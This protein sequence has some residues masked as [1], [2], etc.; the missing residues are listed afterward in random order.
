VEFDEAVEAISARLAAQR[1]MSRQHSH[2]L[3][4]RLTSEG[5]KVEVV[6]GV[7]RW[8]VQ[9]HDPKQPLLWITLWCSVYDDKASW[10][11]I[12]SL[13]WSVPGDAYGDVVEFARSWLGQP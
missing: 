13:D 5:Y 11:W 10:E 7:G 1:Q 6:E 8:G 3:A 9:V 4:A 2:E 12:R